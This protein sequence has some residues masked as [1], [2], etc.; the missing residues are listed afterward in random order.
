MDQLSTAKI[1]EK[2]LA[3]IK[4]SLPGI[5][6]EEEEIRQFYEI[7]WTE[8]EKHPTRHW[9]GRQIKNAFQTALALADREFQESGS[10][11]R[12]LERPILRGQ[13]FKKV[14][15]TSAHFD[16]YFATLHGLE[17]EDAYGTLAA[18]EEI[19]WD[20]IPPISFINSNE[21][22]PFVRSRKPAVPEGESFVSEDEDSDDVEIQKLKLKLE[23]KLNRKYAKGKSTSR[24]LN[25][26][27]ESENEEE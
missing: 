19:R 15:H 7:L 22:K 1:W 10:R 2:N 6:V 17:T 8:N 13:H 3:R 18:R 11:G 5:D 4:T 24:F 21:R 23:R 12:R 25:L 27:L 9:N 14:A 26:R 20:R 16:D